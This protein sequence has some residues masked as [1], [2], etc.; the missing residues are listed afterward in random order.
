MCAARRDLVVHTLLPLLP[1]TA[2]TLLLTS[3]VVTYLWSGDP[4]RRDRARTVV[5]MLLMG[6]SDR[7]IRSGGHRLSTGARRRR[8]AAAR[9]R[10]ATAPHNP[11]REAQ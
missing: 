4:G 11:P 7:H 9:R 10:T 5:E 6:R 3:T 8:S 1:V 2:L